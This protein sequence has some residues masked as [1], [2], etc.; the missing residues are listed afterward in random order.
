VGWRSRGVLYWLTNTL[1][2]ELSNHQMLAIAASVRPL[3]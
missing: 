1:L 3:R 2:E